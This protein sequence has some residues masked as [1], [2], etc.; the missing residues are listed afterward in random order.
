MV[1]AASLDPRN[2]E[3]Q[4]DLAEA[5]S[6]ARRYPQADSMYDRAIA[7]APE[8]YHAYFGKS[9]NLLWWKGDVEGARR[10]MREAETRIGK[11][12]FVR[13]MCVACFD[14]AGPLAPDYEHVLDQLTLEGFAPNDSANYYTARAYRAFMRGEATPQRVYW[15]SARMVTEHMSRAEP[16][17]AYFHEQLST[18]YAGLGR[19][20]QATASVRT[21]YDLYRAHGDTALIDGWRRLTAATNLLLLGDRA[22]AADTLALLL[23]DS[24]VFFLT[25]PAVTVDPFWLKLKG[26][27]G[28][29]AAVAGH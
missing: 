22:A 8:Q 12:E 29:D 28:F 10:V 18:I 17:R 21:A 14:W 27:R 3:L 24:N 26:V 6:A 15:D 7:L 23:A 20:D 13:K 4:G 25:R 16:D 5:Y 11:V 1:R 2:A 19:R 9:R